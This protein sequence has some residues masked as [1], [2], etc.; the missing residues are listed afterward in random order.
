MCILSS[1]SL[2]DELIEINKQFHNGSIRYEGELDGLERIFELG[3][4]IVN[5]TKEK[6]SSDSSECDAFCIDESH[7]HS[8]FSISKRMY[9]NIIL[10]VAKRVAMRHPFID[11]N[12][13][14]AIKYAEIKLGDKVPD[15]V[16]F[17]LDF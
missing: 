11:G 6:E 9:L 16:F 7:S 10:D 3:M 13:R 8:F 4:S 17:L 12:K 15:W 14:T 5:K 1:K 2:K